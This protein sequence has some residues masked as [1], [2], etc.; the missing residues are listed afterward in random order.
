MADGSIAAMSPLVW[1]HAALAVCAALYLAW[2][3]I[4]FNPALPKATGPLYTAGVACI[5]GAVVFGVAAVVLLVRGA[6]ALA[7]LG[8][9]PV[10]LWLV[11]V[12]GAVAYVVLAFATARLFARPVTTELILFVG[13]A[14]LEAA[15][16]SAAAGAG[17]LGAASLVLVA[18]LVAA[19][20]AGCLV[21]YV[22]Y[23][24]LG[25]MPSFIVGAAPLAAVGILSIAEALLFAFA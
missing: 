17:A 14:A 1:G 7:G 23:F 3:W 25:P 13:W 9:P 2:W 15:V 16:L 20:F 11:G 6:G 4:F 10:P 5:V 12:A 8:S 19:V 24:N 22:L 18:V 21:C